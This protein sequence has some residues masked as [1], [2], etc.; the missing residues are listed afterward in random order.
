MGIGYWVLGAETQ[1][2]SS[3]EQYSTVPPSE[4]GGPLQSYYDPYGQ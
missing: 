2:G 1:R 4:Y 3:L